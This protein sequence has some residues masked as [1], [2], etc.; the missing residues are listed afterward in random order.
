MSCEECDGP[1]TVYHAEGNER[2]IT[3]ER[4]IIDL[5]LGHN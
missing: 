5:I 2:G 3:Q 4:V 1:G